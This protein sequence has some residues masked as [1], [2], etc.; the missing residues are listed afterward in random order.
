[1]HWGFHR[2]W[3]QC[4][5]FNVEPYILTNVPDDGGQGRGLDDGAILGRVPRRKRGD[6]SASTAP[7]SPGGRAT[8]GAS[9][10][11]D[12][13]AAADDG[14]ARRQPRA[15][16]APRRRPTIPAPVTPRTCG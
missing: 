16:R 14:S 12:G 4:G 6:G 11:G 2:D 3:R 15:R 10:E 5:T 13:S 7:A 9:A 8:H 1:M